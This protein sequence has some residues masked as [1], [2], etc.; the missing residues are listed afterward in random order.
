MSI[1]SGWTGSHATCD[2]GSTSQEFRDSV[3]Q[4][5]NYFRAMAGVPADVHFEDDFNRK[6]Q[7]AALMFS[8]N[9]KLTHDPDST[10]PCYSAEAAQ[11]AQNSNLFLGVYG[12]EAIDGYIEDRGNENY[13]VAHRR[14]LLYPRTKGMGTGDIPAVGV[15]Q[16]TNVL[17][18]RGSAYEARLLTRDPYVAW[19][20]PGYVPYQLVFPRWSVSVEGADFSQATVT[21]L[22]HGNRVPLTML[23][24]VNGPGE[25]TLVW[26]PHIP[27]RKRPVVDV[28]YTVLVDNMLVNGWTYH[29]EYTVVI[30]D[31]DS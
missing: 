16:A 10:W 7:K 21:M 13:F 18:V 23:K 17:W 8:A 3:L 4:R 20:P 15:Y 5:I 14:W 22:H 9:G 24:P 19:P 2:E 27:V 12:R 1:N 26:E 29:F 31:P 30:F 6:A 25:N 28:W 11:A